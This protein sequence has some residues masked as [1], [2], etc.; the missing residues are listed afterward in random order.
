V[1]TT[2]PTVDFAKTIA[3]FYA[4]VDPETFQ[5]DPDLKVS[6]PFGDDNLDDPKLSDEKRAQIIARRETQQG[7]RF[8]NKD[9]VK[10]GIVIEPFREGFCLWLIEEGG[11]A[12]RA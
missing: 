8:E 6:S 5:E 10:L 3:G 4:D 1:S 7:F 2:F 12:R 9:G 11:M